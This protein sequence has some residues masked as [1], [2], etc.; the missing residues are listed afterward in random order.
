MNGDDREREHYEEQLKSARNGLF[1]VLA[2]FLV[3]ML[4]IVL[5]LT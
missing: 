3:G 1:V 2:V 5:A 4:L